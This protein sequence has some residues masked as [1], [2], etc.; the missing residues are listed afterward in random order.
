[1][2]LIFTE[3]HTSSTAASLVRGDL[4]DEA[5][6]LSE[7]LVELVPGD[8]EGHG[9]A[10]LVLLTD[11]RRAARLDPAGGLVLLEDQD[12]AAWD[13]TRINHG[14]AHLAKAYDLHAAGPFQLQA[15]IAAAHA[16]APSFSATDWPLVVR[17]YDSLVRREP[18]AVVALNRAVAVSYADGAENGLRALAPLADELATYPYFH[19]A[20]AELLLRTGRHADATT[21][22]DDALQWCRNDAERRH[23]TARRAVAAG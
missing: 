19:S 10:A 3:G 5:V 14:L 12:R 17:L 7:L 21:A 23:L 16:T 18:T 13:R 22:F 15:A 8:A 1:V 4:C 20:R 11:A 9:L 6:W 2:F